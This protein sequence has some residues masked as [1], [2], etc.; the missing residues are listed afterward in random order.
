L[1]HID[2]FLFLLAGLLLATILA[3][4]LRYFRGD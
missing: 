4:I 3:E 2:S 1:H